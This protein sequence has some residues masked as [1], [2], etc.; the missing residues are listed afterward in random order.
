MRASP[1]RRWGLILI[2]L[3][4]AVVASASPGDLTATWDGATG[5]WTD[6]IHWTTDPLYPDNGNGGQ[7]FGAVI[8]GGSVTLNDFVTVND[9]VLDA[10]LDGGAGFLTVQGAAAWNGGT[11]GG[12]GTLL[13]APGGSLDIDGG[14]GQALD[15]W[16]VLN[17]GAAGWSGGTLAVEGCG[18]LANHGSLET[19]G[20]TVSGTG[21]FSNNG[22]LSKSGLD[23]LRLECAFHNSGHVT[24]DAGV[25]E[26]RGQGSSSGT[27]HLAEGAAVEV[28]DRY[29]LRG[30]AVT[31]EGAFRVPAED[32][33][34]LSVTGPVSIENL[35][36]DGLSVLRSDGTV[37]VTN[38]FEMRSCIAQCHVVIAEGATAEI[39]G[40]TWQTRLEYRSLTNNGT[41][42]DT[43]GIRLEDG[44]TVTNNALYETPGGGSISGEEDCRFENN[45][46][47]RAGSG[48][49]Q[50]IRVT[51]DNRAVVEVRD[52]DLVFDDY[53][54]CVQYQWGTGTLTGGTWLVADGG[55]I[56][57]DGR[58]IRES[59]ATVT[60]SGW[61]STW[62][63]LQYLRRNAGSLTISADQKFQTTGG[64]LTNTGT[65]T[66]AGAASEL[67]VKTG[68]CTQTAGAIVLAG[69][70]FQ[71]S[72]VDI[73]GGALQ[74]CGVVEASLDSAGALAP[75]DPAGTI[76]ITGQLRLL[77]SAELLVELGGRDQGVEHDLVRVGGAVTLGGQLAVSFLDGFDSDVASSDVL[78]ILSTDSVLDGA[79]ANVANG[80]TLPTADGV[81]FFDVH[82]GPA[83]PFSSGD[84]VLTDYRAVPEP[85]SL[86]LLAL[87]ALAWLRRGKR[88][89]GV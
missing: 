87:G 56:D 38:R 46:T 40:G 82:Y 83:S 88:D 85:A 8:E 68:G 59:H 18:L 25:M 22:E 17:R 61:N 89:R 23:P 41:V 37:T 86:S 47:F 35:Q 43:V 36:T 33:T 57:V 45:G 2:P 84:V 7:S 4:P 31:G 53:E 64:A 1:C 58:S 32:W 30:G 75:G 20:G 78:V 72:S 62:G 71:A 79:F 10:D 55:E 39:G 5:D 21:T 66:I 24:L 70:T 69:G 48:F 12:R 34:Y 80:E 44:S 77:E 13:V 6:P 52:I 16:Q 3:L 67:S 65:I 9:L 26:L 29:E 27:F 76:E 63:N 14:G 74:G 73:Q 11:M 15:G 54:H 50:T 28:Y 51:F 19:A 81:G 60:I 49:K 42:R